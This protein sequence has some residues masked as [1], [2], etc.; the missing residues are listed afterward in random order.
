MS[1]KLFALV[2]SSAVGLAM[3]GKG[4]V[5]AINK[6]TDKKREDFTDAEEEDWNLKS[7]QCTD[8]ERNLKYYV[9]KEKFKGICIGRYVTA[10]NIDEEVKN[11]VDFAEVKQSLSKDKNKDKKGNV[12]D[13][14]KERKDVFFR[15]AA[16]KKN[17][18]TLQPVVKGKGDKWFS[19]NLAVLS[20]EHLSGEHEDKNVEGD[21]FSDDDL[22]S[23]G[24]YLCTQYTATVDG[25]VESVA[26]GGFELKE[27][28]P[29]LELKNKQEGY[30]MIFK[31]GHT[32]DVP[33]DKEE[34]GAKLLK[35][36][37]EIDTVDF[38]DL[39]KDGQKVNDLDLYWGGPVDSK[40]YGSGGEFRTDKEQY[41]DQKAEEERRQTDKDYQPD[42]DFEEKYVVCVTCCAYYWWLWIVL[43]CV[44]LVGI[45]IAVFF[46]VRSRNVEESEEEEDDEEGATVN[47][48]G[49]PGKSVNP[50]P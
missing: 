18:K 14:M 7:K 49:A 19:P 26:I 48:Y 33:A 34:R 40:F 31:N 27:R 35:E 1:S 3:A 32:F 12:L 24:S 13:A 17:M 4:D 15:G 41:E 8:Q 43:G 39:K 25:K 22:P 36:K 46:V 44:A 20:G 50:K 29:V 6:L 42:S 23:T 47:T 9:N 37:G 45:G 28:V 16:L 2:G 30:K 38:D 10:D 11:R 21:I 5:K